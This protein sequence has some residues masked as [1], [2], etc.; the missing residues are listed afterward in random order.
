MSWTVLCVSDDAASLLLYQSILEMDGH[1][2]L[3]AV[4]AD[5]A[6]M[7]SD[8]IGIDCIVVDCEDKGI[9]ITR[10]FATARP[11]IPILC[12][13]DQAEVQLQVYWETGMFVSKEEAIEQLP[14]CVCEVLKRT[15]NGSVKGSRK[16]TRTA[17][18]ESRA[19][20]E[21]LVRWLLPW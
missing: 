7:V 13:S 18:L 11:G 12:V 20:H 21:A 9:S 3:A 14:R 5:E 8:G 10:E 19:L 4:G 16:S 1:T 17:N 15:M 6:L 2:V